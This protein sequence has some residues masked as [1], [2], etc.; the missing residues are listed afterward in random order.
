MTLA[1]TSKLSLSVRYIDVKAEKIDNST[2][3][4]FKIVLVSFQVEDKLKKTRFFE[5]IFLLANINMELILEVLF[6][7]LSNANI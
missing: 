5:K 1:Y 4:T 3:E 7:I 6:L 2:I